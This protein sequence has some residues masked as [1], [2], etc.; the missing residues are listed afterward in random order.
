MSNRREAIAWQVAL[1]LQNTTGE[2]ALSVEM[3]SEY[4]DS[5]ILSCFASEFFSVFSQM[6]VD[7]TGQS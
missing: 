3:L 6:N 2:L 4:S 5:L 7:F 1:L